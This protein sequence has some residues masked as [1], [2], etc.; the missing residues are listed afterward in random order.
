MNTAGVTK[1]INGTKIEG[2]NVEKSDGIILL[3]ICRYFSLY[4]TNNVNFITG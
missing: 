2:K 4:L 3:K 1:P